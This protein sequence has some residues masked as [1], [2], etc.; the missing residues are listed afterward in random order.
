[1]RDLCAFGETAGAESGTGFRGADDD[2]WPAGKLGAAEPDEAVVSA[3]AWATEPPVTTAAP[4]D[5]AKTQR[6][7]HRSDAPSRGRGSCNR[8]VVGVFVDTVDVP[9][10]SVD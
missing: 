4:T 8:S 7:S 10:L 9:S 6:L 1:M 3:H 2:E 5:V